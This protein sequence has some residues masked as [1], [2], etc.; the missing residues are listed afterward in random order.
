MP[1]GAIEGGDCASL[2]ISRAFVDA[3]LAGRA[4][5]A[6]PGAL[7]ATLREAYACQ[8]LAIGLWPD[9]IAGWKVGSIAPAHRDVYGEERLAGPI[10]RQALFEASSGQAVEF[11]VFS[12]GF[13]AV[14]AE[15]VFR[16]ARDAPA[17]KWE[18]SADEASDIAE[19]LHIGIETA[20]S[21]LATINDLGPLAIVSDFGNN[22]GLIVGSPVVA[23]PRVDPQRL[24]S[25]VH[26][27][28][29]L[30][31]RGGGASIPGGP[32]ASLR[33]VLGHCARRGRPL[34]RGQF[35]S[36]G[37]TTGVHRIEPGQSARASFSG[38]GVIA[39]RAKARPGGE[40]PRG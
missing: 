17:Q 23:W 18:W 10:F 19:T 16:M 34:R 11:P 21:P 28:D 13:A 8:E 14:E 37:A 1:G 31:G 12:G 33:W 24:L 36:T 20:G 4:L 6:F 26:F 32:L 9:E 39:C 22:D 25:E 27:E 15:L 3:R 29:R 40:K 30:A 7:P 5:A 38:A 2:S 35:V